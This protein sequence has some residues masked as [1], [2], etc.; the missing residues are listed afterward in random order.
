MFVAMYVRTGPF[1][2]D[3]DGSCAVYILL[4]RTNSCFSRLIHCVTGAEFTHASLSLNPG[5]GVLYSFARRHTHLPLPAGFAQERVDEGLMGH[6]PQIPCALYRIEI[7]PE[8]RQRIETRLAQMQERQ[9]KLKY[10]LL[11]PLFCLMHRP[12]VRKDR[13]FCSQFV[14]HLLCESGALRLQKPASLYHPTDFLHHP[15]LQL[16]YRGELQ[17]LRTCSA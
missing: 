8:V 12:R 2:M 13:F 6:D 7:S 3:E 1:W 10:S 17:G 11:G 4:I 5:N 16:C 15:E 9:R 14:A